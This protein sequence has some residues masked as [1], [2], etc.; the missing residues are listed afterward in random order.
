MI[1]S[2]SDFVASSIILPNNA[3]KSLIFRCA[4][5]FIGVALYKLF[6]LIAAKLNLFAPYL[7]FAEDY[8]QR[9]WYIVSRRLSL[10][11]SLVL[12]FTLLSVLAQLFGTLLWGLDSP[13]YL[14]QASH[15][16]ASEVEGVLQ[17]DPAYIVYLHANGSNI[18]ALNDDLPH[19]VGANLFNPNL[20]ISLTGKVDRG[21]RHVARPTR[22]E[23]GGRI[24]LDDQGFSVSPDSFAMVTLAT[25]D[26]GEVV[27]SGCPT[28]YTYAGGY[29]SWGCTFNNTFSQQLLDSISTLPQVHWD[30]ESD[31]KVDIHYLNFRRSDNVWASI[32]KGTGTV[33]M[34]QVFTVTKGR[35]RHTFVHSTTQISM[36]TEPTV[37]FRPSEISDLLRRSWSTNATEQDAPLVDDLLTHITTAQAQNRSFMFGVNT[38]SNFT[39]SQVS[40]DYLTYEFGHDPVF[41]ALRV[42]VTN[43]TLIRSETVEHAPAPAEQCDR[44][45]QNQAYGGR[46]DG[47]DCLPNIEIPNG[48]HFLG[49]VDTSAVLIVYGLGDGRSNVSAKALDEPVWEWAT[50]TNTTNSV[51]DLLL[52]RG[53][54]VSV[55]PSLV[56]VELSTVRV[57]MSQLQIFLVVLAFVLGSVGW[58]CVWTLVDSHWSNSFLSNVVSTTYPGKGEGHQKPGYM[59]KLPEVQLLVEEEK[60]GIAVGGRTIALKDNAATPMESTSCPTKSGNVEHVAVEV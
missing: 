18:A 57:A 33:G 23:A 19:I 22:P 37:P 27:S 58:L 30:D 50:N 35:S 60:V 9:G 26:D 4:E 41:S 46:L 7:M 6:S 43:I 45:F 47:T 5:F 16:P 59:R 1:T 12:C 21:E 25:T 39:A 24:W 14:M 49:Q 44:P 15:V 51:D 53:Y 54:L 11:S 42:S 36:L 52:A 34:K 40:W 2:T 3:V 55:S 32:G 38:A 10:G 17:S 56:T 20:N 13:G 48:S 31:Q 28:N 8:I 29:W